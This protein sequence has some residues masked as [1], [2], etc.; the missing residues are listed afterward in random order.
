MSPVATQLSWSQIVESS[1]IPMNTFKGPYLFDVLG[2]K[3]DYLENDLET[4]ILCELEKFILEF[5]KGEIDDASR[6][7]KL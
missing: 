4:A 7:V 2:L 6:G 1:N 3:D 5:G